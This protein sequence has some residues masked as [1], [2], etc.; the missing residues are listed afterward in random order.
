MSEAITLEAKPREII[1]KRVRHLRR[2]DQ[3]PVVLY[4]PGLAPMPLTV[5]RRA[6]KEVLA[7][8]GST[9]IVELHVGK[10]TYQALVREVQRHVLKDVILHVDFYQVAMDRLIR[11]EVPVVAVGESPVV[12]S[13]EAILVDVTPVVEIEALPGDLVPQLEVDV[14]GLTEV[15]AVVHV[16]DLE[17][18]SAVVVLTDPDEVLLKTD[19]AVALVEEEVAEEEFLV[20][21]ERAAD[22]VEVIAK[23]KAEEESKGGAG[24]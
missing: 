5:E 9:N 23:G 24:E 6:L 11:A 10:E 15:G 14:S 4:G 16:R 21:E 8:A 18:P 1:G 19:Y 20:A 7:E 12:A 22:E 17:V 13:G 3:I 2:A